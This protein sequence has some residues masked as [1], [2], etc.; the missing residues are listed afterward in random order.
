L[1]LCT[2]DGIVTDGTSKTLLMSEVRFPPKDASCD[3]RGCAL[4]EPWAG[5]FTA[6]ATPN[7]GWDYNYDIR[8]PGYFFNETFPE[9]PVD[10][11]GNDQSQLQVIAR[12][13]HRGVNAVF[14]DGSVQFVADQID[15]GVWQEL[16]TMNS[17]K[18]VEGY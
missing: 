13:N 17:G 8:P 7:N 5:Y 1:P 3:Y 15:I 18:P 9:L 16:S 6:A 11:R 12:S 10:I 2:N 4:Q 14:C